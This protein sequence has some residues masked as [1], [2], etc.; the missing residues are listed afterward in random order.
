MSPSQLGFRELGNM[1]IDVLGT[2]EQKENKG[3]NTGTKA[4]LENRGHQ[5]QRNTF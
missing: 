4:F 3:G 5:N 2:P 1:A